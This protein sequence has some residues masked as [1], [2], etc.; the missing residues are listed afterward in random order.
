MRK[1][2]SINTMIPTQNMER[3]VASTIMQGELYGVVDKAIELI[4]DAITKLTF[5]PGLALKH[6]DSDYY[7]TPQK[8]PTISGI[9]KI[10]GEGFKHRVSKQNAFWYNIG[11]DRTKSILSKIE[12]LR[13]E[14]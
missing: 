14:K 8:E 2:Y 12:Y 7:L 3:L 6:N 4:E 10:E 5:I 13:P 9:P 1:L 11:E